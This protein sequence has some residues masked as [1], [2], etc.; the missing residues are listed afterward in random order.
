MQIVKIWRSIVLF[1]V[2]ACGLALG[3]TQLMHAPTATTILAGDDTKGAG[4]G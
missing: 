4:G 1:T 3:A 2:L